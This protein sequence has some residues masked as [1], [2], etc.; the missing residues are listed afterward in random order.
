MRRT[1]AYSPQ[2]EHLE[3]RTYFA[4]VL[5]VAGSLDPTFGVGGEAVI[6]LEPFDA[7]LDLIALPGGG[8]LVL[9]QHFPQGA[10]QPFTT[11]TRLDADGV[12]DANFGAGGVG[13]L[14]R[15]G[16]ASMVVATDGRIVVAGATLGSGTPSPD[17]AEDLLIQRLNADGSPDTTFG[18]AGSTTTDSAN[19][20]DVAVKV[21]QQSDGKLLVVGYEQK[22]FLSR[23]QQTPHIAIARYTADGLPDAGFGV[24]GVVI[25]DVAG[26]DAERAT[27]ATLQDDG[28]VV[29]VGAAIRREESFGRPATATQ[30]LLLR[31]NADGSLDQTFSRDGVVVT[32]IKGSATDVE[33]DAGRILVATTRTVTGGR[34]A[35]V[36][37][38]RA[39]GARA[40]GFGHDGVATARFGQVLG[41]SARNDAT[42]GLEIDSLH[43][44][45]LSA[46]VNSEG[47]GLVRFQA[48]GRPD[49]SFGG[50]GFTVTPAPAVSS[51]LLSLQPDGDLLT[52]VGGT[53]ITLRRHLGVA[54]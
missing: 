43:R 4:D 32:R 36:V 19:R 17:G 37:A 7:A 12:T 22:A 26:I 39:N 20:Q 35:S 33:I 14:L 40:D 8:L 5:A 25:T 6:D 34:A 46:A 2:F 30:V 15:P 51:V 13:Q 18:T 42:G 52:A 38:F 44:I 41:I 11:V 50:A 53:D 21:L 49:R 48:N 24:G 27:A 10:E 3:R 1:Q 45:V 16:G 47:I 23:V 9:G 28:K 54:R 29:V 31:Y